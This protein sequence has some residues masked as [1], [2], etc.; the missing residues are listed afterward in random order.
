MDQKISSNNNIITT[1]YVD[2]VIDKELI[3]YNFYYDREDNKSTFFDSIGDVPIT[4]TGNFDS[5]QAMGIRNKRWI[6]FNIPAIDALSRSNTF[7]KKAVNYLSSKPLIN[8]IDLNSAEGQLTSEEEKEVLEYHK[9]QYASLKAVLTKGYTYGGA[10]GLLWFTNEQSKEALKKPL[11]IKKIKKG[12]FAGIKPLA[13]WFQVEPALDKP[14]I[15]RVGP[16]TGINDARMIGLP[17]YYNVNLNGGMIGDSSRSQFLVHVSRLLIYNAEMPSFIETQ[18]ERYWG[19]SIVELAWNELSKDSRLWSATTKSA[20]KNNMGVL[21][22]DG[23]AL[24]GTVTSNV[25]RRVQSRISLIK[26][27][28]AKN[29]VPISNKDSFEFVTSSLSGSKEILQLSNSRIAGAFRVPMSVFFPNENGDSEDK[30]YITSLPELEDTQMRVLRQWYDILLPVIIKSKIGR[31]V[32]NLKYS[33]NPIETQ[34]LK[35]KAETAE[36]NSK[37]IMNLYNIGAV[38]K[39]SAIRMVDVLSKNPEYMSDSINIKYKEDIL[40]KAENGEFITSN[41]DKIEIAEAL[42]KF[43]GENDKGLAGTNNPESDIKGSEGGDNKKQ[44]KPLKRNALN[45]DKGKK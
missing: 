3:G 20:E 43:K 2:R 27:G 40:K 35:E 32:T 13:R 42:N 16:G 29:V 9:T 12:T 45:P 1:E 31:T 10:A 15:T 21:K 14:L 28:T 7:V 36:I 33:F 26:D 18:I 30:S 38:D 5:Q 6:T 19:S 37:T 4:N 39:A 23:L 41:S 17:M 22:I 8:G 34:T 25:K 24:A 44:K 11:I